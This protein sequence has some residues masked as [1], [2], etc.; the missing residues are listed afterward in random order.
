MFL[1][2]NI[3]WHVPPT[4]PPVSYAYANEGQNLTDSQLSL[5]RIMTKL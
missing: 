4:P 1:A 5:Y 3:F 2:R